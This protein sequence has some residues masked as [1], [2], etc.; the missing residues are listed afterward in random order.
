MTLSQKQILTM[1]PY[2]LLLP[3]F[4]LVMAVLGYGVASG[5]VLSFFRMDLS[6][7]RTFVGLEN[8]RNV[9]ADP[10]V[11]AAF[12]RTFVFVLCVLI[13]SLLISLGYALSINSSNRVRRFF[14]GVSMV[15]F[16]VSGV[17]ASVMWR[18]MVAGSAGLINRATA[19]LGIG[20]LP[21]LSSSMWAFVL[22]ILAC[23][24][25]I[26]PFCTLLILSGLQTIDKELY[27][28]ARVDGAGHRTTFLHI[29]MPLIK[30]MVGVSVIWISYLAFSMFDIVMA[31]TGGGPARA[32]ELVSVR[33]YT[34]AFR[35]YEFGPASVL[36]VLLLSVNILFSIVF[37]KLFDVSGSKD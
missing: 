20:V 19:V 22:L 13:L 21:W 26:T 10:L 15:P 25:V 35:Y 12:T 30:P 9:L 17:A 8:W 23:A 31:L 5:F 24:W 18:F 14:S 33:L 2:L 34:A 6:L 37:Y 29:T 4:A 7:Q 1:T 27:D 28:S 36:M 11:Q 16:F 3:G 32:T